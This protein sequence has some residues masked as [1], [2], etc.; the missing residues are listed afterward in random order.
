[1]TQSVEQRIL[2]LEDIENI[3]K[4]RNSYSYFSNVDGTPER[5]RKFAD[6]FV[7]DG[8]L[9][10]GFG[11]M[12]GRE[13]IFEGVGQASAFWDRFAHLTMNGTVD[14]DGDEGTGQ[15]TG[16]Y[17]FTV[18]DDD[19]LSWGLAYYHDRYM[20]TP[21]GWKFKSINVHA[22]FFDKKWHDI[23]PMYAELNPE[24]TVIRN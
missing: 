22:I 8:T 18:K 6:N 10:V 13:A 21:D 1:M 4:L 23:L 16:L 12:D 14:V 11:L 17:P 3:R 19:Q 9:D 24:C 5:V 20:R 15:W 2:R 7:A